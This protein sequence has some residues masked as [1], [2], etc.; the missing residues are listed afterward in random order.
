[1]KYDL[2]KGSILKNM[3]RFSIPYLI[4]SFL[5]TFYG[6]MDLLIIGQYNGEASI[7][8]VSV[9]SQLTHFLTVVI[10][11]LLMGTTVSI[12]HSVGSGDDRSLRKSVGN[13]VVLS[14]VF[15][16][17]LTV[18]LLISTNLILNLL[19][20]PVEAFDET[21]RYA[22]VCFAG[23]PF[24]VFYNVISSIFRGLGDSRHPMYFVFAAGIVNIILDVILIGP[25]Q[26]G[27]M[28][29][30]IGTITAQAFSVLVAFT[31]MK[32]SERFSL[33]LERSDFEISSD[34]VNRLLKVGLP[35]SVQDAC[36]QV[37][38]L[39]ITMIANMRGVE[40]AAAVGIVEK[41]IGF[42]FLVPSAMLSTVSAFAAQNS[43]AGYNER[44]FKGLYYGTAITFCVGM[45]FAVFCFFNAE[46][47]VGLFAK[48]EPEVVRMGAQY[49]KSYAFDCP[50]AGIH[51]CFSGF[52]SAY[53]KSMVSFVHNII[54]IVTMR[55]PGAYYA[56]IHYPDTLFPMGMAAPLGSLISAII[57]IGVFIYLK[58]RNKLNVSIS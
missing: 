23:V 4:S 51:F 34:M 42:L 50:I 54:S 19:S 28:G 20:V 27:A 36:I 40:V 14:A 8:G 57:C 30:A 22:L 26:M 56:S 21:R 12:S 16:I 53:Q 13:T 33:G 41:V 45:V 5:Q 46:T 6:L 43:G 55:I 37:S 7:T 1:M 32:K 38:F 49:L 3:L 11:G 2:T 48:K 47:V 31:Y 10:V 15:S 58:R 39:V 29:A 25:L 9:G 17:V 18:V 44:A 24:I 52:F 35:I